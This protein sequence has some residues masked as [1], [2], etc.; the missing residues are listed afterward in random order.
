MR[1]CSPFFPSIH[2]CHIEVRVYR[3]VEK[4]GRILYSVEGKFL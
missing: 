2:S 1:H 3:K 4:L